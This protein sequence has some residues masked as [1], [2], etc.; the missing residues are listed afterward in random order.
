MVALRIR[1][2]CRRGPQ[3]AIHKAIRYVDV[4]EPESVSD[5]VLN[6]LARNGIAREIALDAR[7]GVKPD[8]ASDGADVRAAAFVAGRF[9]DDVDHDPAV[10]LRPRLGT[11]LKGCYREAPAGHRRYDVAH[12]RD[13]ARHVAARETGGLPIGR[14]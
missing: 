13:D 10:A 4:P 5:L 8:M 2:D 6:R 1:G 3:R 9:A 14:L 11:R 7:R 12:R